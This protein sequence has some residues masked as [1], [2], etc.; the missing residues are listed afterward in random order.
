MPLPLQIRQMPPSIVPLLHLPAPP[1]SLSL[2]CSC[3]SLP[4]P[5]NTTNSAL[6]GAALPEVLPAAAVAVTSAAAAAAAAKLSELSLPSEGPAGSLILTVEEVEAAEGLVAES[7]ERGEDV[8]AE[9]W[10]AEKLAWATLLDGSGVN[11]HMEGLYLEG[12]RT[13][14]T[15]IGLLKETDDGEG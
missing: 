6:E 1:A 4:C 10:E 8:A 9:L 15:N 3:P 11:E 12:L 2:V 13:C 14:M 7:R 5:G